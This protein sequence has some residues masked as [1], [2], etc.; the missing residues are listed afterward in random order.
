MNSKR[1]FQIMLGGLLL[2]GALSIGSVVLANHLLQKSALNLSNLQL[3][4]RVLDEQQ[5]ALV[6]A[7]KDIETY[8][9]LKQVAQSIV[10]QEKD[11]ARAVRE[12][13]TFAQD[14]NI[15]IASINFPTSNL[16][17]VVPKPAAPPPDDANSEPAAPA[18]PAAPAITQVEPV[19]GIPGVFL[20]EIIVQSDDKKPI[21]FEQL[22]KF[23]ERL[24]QN[25]RTAHVTNITIRQPDSKDR[26]KLAFTLT[27][28]VYIKP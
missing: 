16:G 28:N 8:S 23:L 6:R 22:T 27:V 19:T 21:S 3:E 2:G 17:Q 4:N 13:T 1:V 5:Q 7:K 20:L 11:Q 18:A 10:P 26:G 25:R 9:E 14:N 12:I 15:T 24:E